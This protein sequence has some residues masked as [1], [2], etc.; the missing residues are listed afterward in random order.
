MGNHIQAAL[1][2][3]QASTTEQQ[4]RLIALNPADLLHRQLQSV[5]S[6]QFVHLAPVVH[7]RTQALF[8]DMC[9]NVRLAHHQRLWLTSLAVRGIDGAHCPHALNERQDSPMLLKRL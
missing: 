3:A 1:A 5:P 6:E 2:A 8:Q 7:R 4:Q 9:A